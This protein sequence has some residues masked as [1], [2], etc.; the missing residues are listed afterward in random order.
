MMM[1]G[2]AAGSAGAADYFGLEHVEAGDAILDGVPT[3]PLSC[4]NLGST[5][6]DGV[7]VRIPPPPP[8]RTTLTIWDADFQSSTLPPG[9][10]LMIQ[11]VGDDGSGVVS[12]ACT[13]VID[14]NPAATTITF[15]FSGAAPATLGARYYFQG[16][17]IAEESGVT[18]VFAPIGGFPPAVPDLC[19]SV[20]FDP[21]IQ[22]WVFD[23]CLAVERTIGGTP[24]PAVDYWEVFTEGS[25]VHYDQMSEVHIRT[26]GTPT[27]TITDETL[28]MIPIPSGC[29]GD[30]D[31]DGDVDF[32]DLNTVLGNW[33]GTGPQGDLFPNGAPDG[34]VNFD[35]LNDVLGHWGQACP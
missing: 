22:Q 17:L 19:G 34:Q 35:D 1:L 23:G 7:D 32:D 12:V 9:S 31:G 14:F 13:A 3:G 5:G 16:D 2:L 25:L 10:T 18:P 4:H 8:D 26:T 29:P 30:A 20:H 6:K 27:L 11:G 15:D 33:G 28:T 24:L 21:V